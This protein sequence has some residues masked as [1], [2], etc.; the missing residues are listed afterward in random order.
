VELAV[1]EI[2]LLF[3]EHQHH[4]LEAVAEAEAVCLVL[5]AV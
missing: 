4:M 2:H 5:A 1:L 3:P